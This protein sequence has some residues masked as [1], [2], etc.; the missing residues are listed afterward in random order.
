MF[1]AG[2]DS[3]DAP[4]SPEGVEQA[5]TIKGEADLVITSSLRRAVDTIE[6]SQLKYKDRAASHL[7]RERRSVSK[8]DFLQ[9]EEF[10][11][12]T[13]QEFVDRLSKFKAQVKDFSRDYRRILII[14]HGIFMM[15]FLGI[16]RDIKNCEF[17]RV[18]L[19]AINF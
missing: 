15:N 17:F 10:K 8:C 12:E 6:N 9:G 7:C 1:N 2:V 4:L 3:V 5:K 19:N 18:D 13:D 11:A 16:N 14:S